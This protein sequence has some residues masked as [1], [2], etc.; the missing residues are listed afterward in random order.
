[1][2]ALA[3]TALLALAG[4]AW[5]PPW[6]AD[7]HANTASALHGTLHWLHRA[8]QDR[9]VSRDAFR[10]SIVAFARSACDAGTPLARLSVCVE[11]CAM[12]WPDA[13][14]A[15][16]LSEEL[17]APCVPAPTDAAARARA[18]PAAVLTLSSNGCFMHGHRSSDAC[19]SQAW[20]D[21]TLLHRRAA[22]RA[23]L[24]DCALLAVCLA[25]AAWRAGGVTRCGLMV[26]RTGVVPLSP[27]PLGTVARSRWAWMAGS[28]ERKYASPMLPRAACTGRAA[29]SGAEASGGDASGADE[30]GG[31]LVRTPPPPAVRRLPS[32]P[33]R[34]GGAPQRGSSHALLDFRAGSRLTRVREDL[35]QQQPQQRRRSRRPLQRDSSLQRALHAAGQL[36]A[37]LSWR[38]ARTDGHAAEASKPAVATPESL[39]RP[40]GGA[41]QRCSSAASSA[42]EFSVA[43]H[44]LAASRHTRASA[45]RQS[46]AGRLPPSAST[47]TPPR[48]PLSTALAPVPAT[49]PV[50]RWRHSVASDAAAT[51]V[52]GDASPV[53]VPALA[54]STLCV[55]EEGTV[56]GRKLQLR[57]QQSTLT[58]VMNR[59]KIAATLL[60][61]VGRGLGER[62]LQGSML[63]SLPGRVPLL[64]SASEPLAGGRSKVPSSLSHSSRSPALPAA[65]ARSEQ[66]SDYGAPPPRS[67]PAACLRAE[68]GTS[69]SLP[70][71]G[72]RAG[73]PAAGSAGGG[74]GSAGA[75]HGSAGAGR[76]S[77][78]PGSLQRLARLSP[79]AHG[80]LASAAASAGAAGS[81]GSIAPEPLRILVH[82]PSALQ[83]SVAAAAAPRAHTPS[84][85]SRAHTHSPA[86]RVTA[87][88]P[89]VMI[90]YKRQEQAFALR[91]KTAL[92]A[93]GRFRVWIDTQIRA[94]RAWRDE[95]AGA[96]E[97]SVAVLFVMSERSL[98]RYGVRCRWP[99]H[100]TCQH[101]RRLHAARA[102]G[103]AGKSF[104]TRSQ[105]RRP[106]SR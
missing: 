40:P 54:G 65:Q 90:S 19:H 55:A 7:A 33:A 68:R 73:S 75:G 92:E 21:L 52:D 84:S 28:P 45:Q 57:K 99:R 81:A 29:G 87:T 105:P 23:L 10:A 88:V 39:A 42:S 6:W 16:W 27:S 60:D 1:M 14:L 11:H 32:S 101:R 83:A 93:T 13:T 56:L 31:P 78:C 41:L 106:S 71:C 86:S 37:S 38:R 95:I 89:Q 69:S 24:R 50:R 63:Q 97:E 48:A 18:R 17:A 79:P 30:K 3:I 43:P 46:P 103:T 58:T 59:T 53:G 49:A 22:A 15:S 44:S 8:P 102:A 12:R 72:D 77:A 4:I 82:T 96:I 76:G 80:S 5:A 2:T 64:A 25:I 61:T 70:D 47:S 66:E 62:T 91:V 34:L 20:L 98:Q 94:G 100:H 35:L 104:T 9:N 67:L 74:H 36:A 26:A 51:A 85:A